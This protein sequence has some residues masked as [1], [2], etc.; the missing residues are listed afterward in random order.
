LY[1]DVHSLMN[2]GQF[3]YGKKVLTERE[4]GRKAI[5]IGGGGGAGGLYLRLSATP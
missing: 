5:R 4:R 2:I 3:C 1:E